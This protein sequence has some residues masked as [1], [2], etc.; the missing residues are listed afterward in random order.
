M[1]RTAI[2]MLAALLGGSI[3]AVPMAPEHLVR[4]ELPQDA[5]PAELAGRGVRVLTQL[6]GSCL[7]LMTDTELPLLGSDFRA[8]RILS[9]PRAELLMLVA[10][11]RRSSLP[12]L[13]GIGELLVREGEVALLRI[14]ESDILELNRLPVEIC[15]LSMEPMKV[16]DAAGL[17]GLVKPLPVADSLVQELVGAVSPDSILGSIRRLQN[18]YTRYSTTDSCRAAINWTLGRFRTYNCD[19]AYPHVFRS[20]YAPNAIGVK[21]GRT[22]PNRSYIICGHVDNTSDQPPNRCPGSDDNASGA[23]AVLEACRVFADCEFDYTVTF[24]GFSG[25]EQGLYGSDSFSNQ[26]YRRRDTILGVLNF[27]MISYGRENMDSTLIVGRSVSPN[28]T[29]LVNAFCASADTYTDLKYIRNMISSGG[30]G[31]DHYYF[32]QRGYL[33]L[34]GE[35]DDFTPKYHTIGDTIGTL[36]Y[37]NCGTNNVPMCTE[38]IKAAVATLARLAGVRVLTGAGEPDRAARVLRVGRAMPDPFRDRTQLGY[39]LPSG[40]AAALRIYDASG[41]LVR[42]FRDLA[43]GGQ[44]VSWNGRD[45]AG[46]Q[47]TPGIYFFRLE[48]KQ[49][50]EFGKTVRIGGD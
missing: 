2:V 18:F 31:S 38:V 39:A 40:Q 1:N 37:R 27:D 34:W 43:H 35:E 33:A 44:S 12:D 20:N 17:G 22:Y 9:D 47:V 24:I 30:Y 11:P 49:T 29:P 36:Y 10:A 4:I 45:C 13:A 14:Q 50:T 5:G 28:C 48:G 32:W 6:P 3:H 46:R 41:A 8:E 23:T 26:A 19:T 21:R 16:G 7:A 25:E 15:R 42:E